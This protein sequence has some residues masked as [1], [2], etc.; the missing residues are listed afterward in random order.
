MSETIVVFY[1]ETDGFVP[2]MDWLLKEVLPRDKKLFAWCFDAIE[3]L[4][5]CGRDLRRPVADYLRD[6]IYELRIRYYRQNYRILYFF[7]AG[8]IAVLSNGLVK[9]AEVPAGE[10]ETAIQRK[11][12]FERS[13]EAHTYYEDWNQ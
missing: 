13:Q 3:K 5:R 7:H 2:V 12:E 9:E 6:G 8:E 1:Q 4:S 11:R 10:I